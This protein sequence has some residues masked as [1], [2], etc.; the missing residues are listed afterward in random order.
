MSILSSAAVVDGVNSATAATVAQFHNVDN[1]SL[2]SGN[3]LYTGGVAQ[4]LNFANTLDR[5]RETGFDGISS[6]GIATGTQQLAAAPLNTTL[7][8]AVTLNTAAQA[9]TLTAVSQTVRGITYTIT[10]GATISVDTGANQEYVF[11]TA[12]NIGAKTVTGIFT[13][14][15]A[16]LQAVQVFFFDQARSSTILDGSTPQGVPSSSMFLWNGALNSGTGGME[17]E[18]SAAGE[19]DGASGSGTNIAAEYEWAAGG[20]VQASGLVTGFSF[21]RS[22]NLQAKGLGTGAITST[23][24]GNTSIVFTGGASAT[25]TI[26]P[27]QK[28]R[29]RG[30]AV[31]ETVLATAAWVPGSSATVPIQSPVVNNAQ[32]NADW[33]QYSVSGPALNGFLAD[34]VGIEE[35]C[36]YDPVSDKYYIERSATQDAMP[37]QNIVAENPALFNGTTMDREYNNFNTT[38]GDTGTKTVG[39]TNGAQQ[40]NFNARGAY[41]TAIASAVTGTLSLQLQWS[42]DAGTTWLNIGP[43]TSTIAA[44]GQIAIEIYPTNWSQAA[45]ATPANITNGATVSTALNA[46]LPR[47]WRVQMIVGTTSA[48]ITAIYVNYIL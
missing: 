15:H 43:A 13:K 37:P 10:A 38:T 44:A 20:P 45:G 42:P 3:G 18:R 24:A 6:A 34:G 30:G 8:G 7:N 25:N 27:G 22:R 4:I 35:E 17:I 33:D 46:P 41:I 48:V 29:L 5:Q 26:Q 31:T 23:T 16:S 28:I 12:V 32:V 19:L 40:T 11:V 21:D 2:G 9:V 47:T 14:N 36:L 1:Q 39:T